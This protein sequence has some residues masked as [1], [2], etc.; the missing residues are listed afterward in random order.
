MMS[1]KGGYSFATVEFWLWACAGKGR[2]PAGGLLTPRYGYREHT[3]AGWHLRNE[4]GGGEE[5]PADIAG[6]G[7]QWLERYWDGR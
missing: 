4:R 5:G 6:Q 7:A 3:A 1:S 2:P